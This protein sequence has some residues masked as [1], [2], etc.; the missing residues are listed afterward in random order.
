MEGKKF[1]I[2]TLIVFIGAAIFGLL[3]FSGAI[4]IGSSTNTGGQGTVV[5]WGTIKNQDIATTLENFNTA[6]PTF[7][8]KYVQKS[9]DTFD[10]DLLEALAS[11]TGPD[12]FFLPDNLVYHYKNKILPIP[13]QSFPLASFK[14]NFAGAGEVFLT[15]NGVLAFPMSIDPL[16][17]YYNRSTLDSSNVIAP[18]SYWDDLVNMV[19]VL[20]QK[21]VNNTIT[22]SAVA[23][24]QFANVEHAQDIITALFMQAG[25]PII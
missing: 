3:V 19:P 25:N 7:V 18:P 21:D 14:S 17:M 24:G 2:I 13:Y 20:T 5:L 9:A 23:M 4:P 8:V 6:N 16:M 12:M 22:K 10:H 15:T 11:G 1:Q